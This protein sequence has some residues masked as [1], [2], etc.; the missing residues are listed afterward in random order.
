VSAGES[1]KLATKSSRKARRILPG[2]AP[3]SGLIRHPF[4]LEYGVRTSGLVAGRHLAS[5]QRNDRHITA[6]YAIAPSVFQGIIVRW[7][8]CR[9]Q[10]PLDAYTFIDL[11]AGMGR[12]M[13][14]AATYSFRSVVGVELHPALA[15]IARRNLAAWRAAG[16]ARVPTRLFCRDAS[17]FP[18]PPGPCVA[19][20][21]NPFGA[22]V[23]RRLLRN[24]SRALAARSTPL[25][26]LYVNNEHDVVLKSEPGFERLFFGQI[27]RS[28]TDAV[29]DRTIL[30]RQPGAEYAAPGWEDCS[31]YRWIGKDRK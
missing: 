18:L 4:D 25:D 11:G 16:R 23:L 28:H 8:R 13:M 14:L 1:G 12:A 7:R 2:L 24:W 15:R 20:L 19:F 17:T 9:P 30:K 29:V 21:F 6:Y 3:K 10:A 31:I 5:G 22:P 26:I 27:R